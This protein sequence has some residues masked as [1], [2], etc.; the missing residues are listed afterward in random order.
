MKT[1][2]LSVLVVVLLVYTSES[3][4][5][6]GKRSKKLKKKM[7]GAEFSNLTLHDQK[8]GFVSRDG[9]FVERYEV[10][11]IIVKINFIYEKITFFTFT[12]Q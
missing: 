5:S 6:H 3:N 7:Q 4:P 1:A 11:K 10:R 9:Y 8:V 2:Y 12:W